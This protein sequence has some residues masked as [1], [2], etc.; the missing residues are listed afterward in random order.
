MEIADENGNRIPPVQA[1]HDP[2]WPSVTLVTVTFEDLGGKTRL[3]LRQNVSAVL[4]QK[5]GAYP[6]WIQMMDKLVEN[7]QQVMIVET[8]M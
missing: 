6:S 4:A 5:T 8:V 2:E 3:T 7:L 1:G